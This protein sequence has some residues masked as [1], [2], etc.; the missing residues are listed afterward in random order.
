MLIV[1]ARGLK[2][3]KKKKKKKKNRPKNQ[4]LP[5]DVVG[6][7]QLWAIPIRQYL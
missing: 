4:R 1:A 3:K 5:N 7:C 2:L 6:K